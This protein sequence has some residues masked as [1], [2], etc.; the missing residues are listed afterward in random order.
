MVKFIVLELVGGGELFDFVALGGRLSDPQAR[1]FYRQ[2]L[3]GLKCVHDNG[4]AHR[5]LKPENLL[6]DNDFVLKISDFGFAA[7]MCGRDD[8]GLMET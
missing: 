3:D 8:S 4:F 2:L 7:P 6:L 1:Y 5:D